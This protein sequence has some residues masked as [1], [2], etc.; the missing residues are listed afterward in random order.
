MQAFAIVSLIDEEADAPSATL[1]QDQRQIDPNGGL[2]YVVDVGQP[3]LID[4]DYAQ[5]RD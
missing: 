4:A 5:G 3:E 1:I 2:P